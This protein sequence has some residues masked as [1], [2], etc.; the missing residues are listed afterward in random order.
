M[1]D[2][3]NSIFANKVTLVLAVIA[4]LVLGLGGYVV[5]GKISAGQTQQVAEEV[6]MPF[7]PE[8]P[9][10][11]LYPRAD[12]NALVLD[13]KRTGSYDQI[14]YELTYNSEGVDRGAQGDINTKEKKGE[15][16]QEILFGSCST[17]GKCVF[18]KDVENGTLTLHIKKGNTA[19][20]MITQWHL[21]KP[22]V[23]LGIL[24]SGDDH[25]TYKIDQATTDLSLIKY[26]ITNDLSGA[27]KL[28]DG[29]VVVGKV[30]A[31]N[32]PQA[33]ELPKGVVTIELAEDAPIGS[34]IAVFNDSKNSWTEYDT[35]ITDGKLTASV[36]GGGAITVL[37]PK[38]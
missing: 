10:A 19:Y 1:S 15:Y 35:N 18:D 30:Y 32:S 8:G 24:T 4:V 11:I 13:I 3:P 22:D 5:Y 33:K 28:P 37:A 38:K 23:A 27:P 7:D 12:G 36:D 16:E 20:R 17:G 34:K 26:V 14:K 9:Y 31:V 2:N 21:Q 25:L 6:D 29:K